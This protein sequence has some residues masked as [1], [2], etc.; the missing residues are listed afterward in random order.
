[1]TS[2]LTARFAALAAEKR[3]ALVTFVATASGLSFFGIGAA[4][5]GL[6][7]GGAMLALGKIG[8]KT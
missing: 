2:R 1:M 3:A 5:W 6:V 4:F 8:R 7:A